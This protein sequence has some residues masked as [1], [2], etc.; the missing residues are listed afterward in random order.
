MLPGMGWV[1]AVGLVVAVVGVMFIFGGMGAKKS[2]EKA[3]LSVAGFGV[4][5]LVLGSLTSVVSGG[6]MWGN[7]FC[8]DKAVIPTALP[9]NAHEAEENLKALGFTAIEF[10]GGSK[11]V[12]SPGNWTVSNTSPPGG[13]EVCKK[14]RL[15]LEVRK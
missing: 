11:S 14:D 7:W 8:S 5:V 10:D 13:R 1:F 12:W 4:A 3:Q 15:T 2:S 9:T 6:V